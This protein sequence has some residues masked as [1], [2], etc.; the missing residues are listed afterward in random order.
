MVR[1]G[2]FILTFI[3]LASVLKVGRIARFVGRLNNPK[4]A[5]D[6]V[7]T[8]SAACGG[9]CVSPVYAPCLGR[10]GP[11]NAPAGRRKTARRLA[12]RRFLQGEVEQDAG[13]PR[14]SAWSGVDVDA[15]GP[16]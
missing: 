2:R 6:A 4:Q 13:G 11:V 10:G 3:D 16:A 5:V 9:D 7:S 1:H 8:V 15:P 12:S 14:G